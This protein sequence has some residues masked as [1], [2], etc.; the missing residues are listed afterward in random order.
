MR[1]KLMDLNVLHSLVI[2]NLPTSN[3]C[4]NPTCQTKDKSKKVKC[5]HLVSGGICVRYWF[6]DEMKLSCPCEDVPF[7][8][9]DTLL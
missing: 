9:L 5:N 4:K 8:N 2:M 7:I 6:T 3:G 1:A